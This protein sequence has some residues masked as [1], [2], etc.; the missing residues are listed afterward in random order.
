MEIWDCDFEFQNEFQ[1]TRLSEMTIEEIK[2]IE[3]MAS[4]I[5]THKVFTCPTRATIAAFN[6]YLQSL[7]ET[8]EYIAEGGNPH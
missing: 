3:S 5:L 2:Q 1:T 7:A 4:L 8:N 6:L